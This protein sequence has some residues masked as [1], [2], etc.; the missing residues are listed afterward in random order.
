MAGSGKPFDAQ[1]GDREQSAR[2]ALSLEGLGGTMQHRVLHVKHIEVRA[3]EL[4]AGS[5]P[6]T[7]LVMVAVLCVEGRAVGDATGRLH[8]CEV[9]TIPDGAG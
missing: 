7:R 1:P 9:P 5:W 6:Q 3:T 8:V 4:A 2:I